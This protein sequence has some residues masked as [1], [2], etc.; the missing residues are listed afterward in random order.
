M[1][2]LNSAIITLLATLFVFGLLITSH[3]LGHFI[4]AKLSG[5]AVIEFAIGM[6]PKIFGFKKGETK[7]TLR[8]LPIGGYNKMLGEQE[9]SD[10][11]RAFSNKSPWKRLGIIIAGAFMNFLIAVVLF[12]LVTYNIGIM[13][14][15]ISSVVKNY[16]AQAAGLQIN[17]KIISVNDMEIKSW[18]SF[19][20][21]V[22]GNNGK[23]FKLIVKRGNSNIEKLLKP[24]FDKKANRYLIGIS[25]TNVKGDIFESVKNG[26]YLTGDSIKQ[27]LAFLGNALHGKVNTAD[28]GGPVAV[29]KLSGEFAAAG[30]WSL[31][32]F[33]AFLS[34][35]LGVINLIPFP[36][37]DGGWVIILLYEGITRRKIDENK[38]G[39][40]NFIGFALLMVLI[41]VVTFHDFTNL[42]LFQKVIK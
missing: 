24:V 18:N 7:Y 37:L 41:V 8:L 4:V 20:D 34:I 9:K 5:V 40:V 30:F 1:I 31:L 36:A 39:F 2:I 27:M 32:Y 13:K 10:D 12:F 14:P 22:T 3:E 21:F 35:N 6:G 29:V 17:D 15:I 11:P 16:P 23:P 38:I 26:L 42:K 28:I 25:G 19:T 33:T